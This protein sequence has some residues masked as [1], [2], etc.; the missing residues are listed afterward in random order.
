MQSR[1]SWLTRSEG[2]RRNTGRWRPNKGKP[3]LSIV[4]ARRLSTR[5]I[6]SVLRRLGV[7]I[8]VITR[9]MNDE[10]I[11]KWR[12]GSRHLLIAI[13]REHGR[14]L[15]GILFA[16][17]GLKVSIWP[18]GLLLGVWASSSECGTRS[19]EK[20]YHQ[21]WEGKSYNVSSVVSRGEKKK[22]NALNMFYFQ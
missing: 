13:K 12:L 7:V 17:C 2:G 1:S 15:G 21:I 4:F 20:L 18:L 3:K 22:K 9:W 19:W 5:Y 14:V 11:N 8:H 10:R 16:K 6:I